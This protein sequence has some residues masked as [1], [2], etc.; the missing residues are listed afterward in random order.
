MIPIGDFPLL[1]KKVMNNM[2]ITK[3]LPLEYCLLILVKQS[4]ENTY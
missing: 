1:C 4:R 2:T 3:K